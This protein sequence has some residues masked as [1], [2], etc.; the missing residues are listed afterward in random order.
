LHLLLVDFP[1]THHTT[2]NTMPNRFHRS[3]RQSKSGNNS[4]GCLDL[5]L[6]GHHAKSGASRS[7]GSSRQSN[8]ENASNQTDIHAVPPPPTKAAPGGS[9]HHTE[10]ETSVTEETL[11]GTTTTSTTMSP[12][13]RPRRSLL[14]RRFPGWSAPLEHGNE[15]DDDE[16]TVRDTQSLP[17]GGDHYTR[18][19]T[20]H[21][22]HQAT[23]PT[24]DHYSTASDQSIPDVSLRAMQRQ[25]RVYQRDLQRTLCQHEL[26]LRASQQA[27][28]VHWDRAQARYTSDNVVGAV[29]SLKKWKGRH[30]YAEKCQGVVT[31]LQSLLRQLQNALNDAQAWTA[32]QASG[33]EA[34][35]STLGGSTR[36][37]YDLDP[38]VYET[39]H[40]E[41]DIRLSSQE[42]KDTWTQAQL[43]Q[44]LTTYLQHKKKSSHHNQVTAVPSPPG[45]PSLPQ[46][47]PSRR[48]V[49][50]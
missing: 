31:Y 23:L 21:H 36:I 16:E 33:D 37:S 34:G 9:S 44:E 15:N 46:Q 17:I 26:Q 29:L 50:I 19:P 10:D 30:V 6:F 25:G 3:R 38:T 7:H 40:Q 47:A 28:A 39:F 22:N 12:R 2:S 24:P 43:L 27:A 20:A 11:A 35:F 8:K 49:E 4:N 14:L 42:D 48:Q 13:P 32:L 18:R 41:I 5:E 45:R 1:T